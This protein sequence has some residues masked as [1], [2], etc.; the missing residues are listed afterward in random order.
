MAVHEGAN[1]FDVEVWITL[2]DL[3]RPATPPEVAGKMKLSRELRRLPKEDLY[4]RVEK[5]LNL[6]VEYRLVR[7]TDS[8]AH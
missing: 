3:K 8:K 4:A 1:P 2:S 5:S 7:I 6:L